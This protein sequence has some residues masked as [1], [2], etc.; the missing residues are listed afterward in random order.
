MPRVAPPRK[1]ITTQ[2][3]FI[4]S[5][6]WMNLRMLSRMLRP[7]RVALKTELKLSS[8]KI[9][10]EASLATSQPEPMQKPTFDYFSAPTSF[11][12]SAVTATEEPVH[13]RAQMNANFCSGVHRAITLV[14]W[15]VLRMSPFFS[16]GYS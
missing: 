12:P 16:G 3:M 9:I 1:T 14:L 15:T 4:G 7:H 10:D 6:N 2:T 8:R 5:W 11:K 13:W